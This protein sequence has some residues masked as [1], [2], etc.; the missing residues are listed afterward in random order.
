MTGTWEPSGSS[1]S[2]GIGEIQV[3]PKHVYMKAGAKPVTQKQRPIPVHMI[4]PLKENIDEFLKAG[5]PTR[6]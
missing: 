4:G 2:P 6:L 3:P 1:S 5:V